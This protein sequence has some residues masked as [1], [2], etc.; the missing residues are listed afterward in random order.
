MDG[1][2]KIYCHQS[3]S[4]LKGTS[5]ALKLLSLLTFLVRFVIHLI[6]KFSSN[7]QNLIHI[8]IFFSDKTNHKNI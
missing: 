2:N 1:M 5:S 4:P 7:M 3:L 8:L 6:Q